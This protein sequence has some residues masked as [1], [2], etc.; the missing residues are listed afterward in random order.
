MFDVYEQT[1]EFRMIETI[2]ETIRAELGDEVEACPGFGRHPKRPSPS[3]GFSAPSPAASSSPSW[4]PAR[5]SP[6]WSP[7]SCAGSS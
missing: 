1:S 4:H 6:A 2:A 5:T 7:G 3:T